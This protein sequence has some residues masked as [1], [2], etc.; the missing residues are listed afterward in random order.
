MLGTDY[1]P[2]IEGE[3]N[4]LLWVLAWKTD[5]LRYQKSSLQ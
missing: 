3:G 2:A 1:C 5:G 4:F